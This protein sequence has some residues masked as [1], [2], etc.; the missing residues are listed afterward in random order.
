MRLVKLESRKVIT[1][2]STRRL[3][4]I[5]D[6]EPVQVR[7]PARHQTTLNLARFIELELH[8]AFTTLRRRF[9]IAQSPA[10]VDL[11]F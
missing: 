4:R 5:R 6:A 10:V 3:P 7:H 2:N 11:S 1:T 8:L 9:E